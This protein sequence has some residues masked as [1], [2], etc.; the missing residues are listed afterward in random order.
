MLG[1]AEV[2]RFASA[3]GD[4]YCCSAVA[5]CEDVDAFVVRLDGE[6]EGCEQVFVSFS[7][8]FQGF[9]GGGIPVGAF[10]DAVLEFVG[11]QQPL[12]AET[13]DVLKLLEFG[14]EVIRGGVMVGSR[15]SV[16][17]Q[18]MDLF[19]RQGLADGGGLLFQPAEGELD[20]C[21][22]A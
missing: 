3:E 1:G 6:A 15:K 20:G 9:P 12:V 18:D 14:C 4:R 19:R 17:Q 11:C 22:R 7:E 16:G 10:G 21:G 8:D 13:W 2:E 5:R